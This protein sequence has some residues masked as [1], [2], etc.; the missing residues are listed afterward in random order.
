MVHKQ[1][2]VTFYIDDKKCWKSG[3]TSKRDVYDRF[4]DEIKKRIIFGFKIHKST[5]FKT[6]KEAYKSEQKLFNEIIKDF[7]GYKHK[8]GNVR[9][10]NF[11]TK[12]KYN[13]ITEIRKYDYNEYKYAWDYIANAGKTYEEIKKYP[14]K[15]LDTAGR[16]RI[17]TQN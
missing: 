16:V 12:D 8:D 5:W 6:Y 14:R 4:K 7:G 17:F 3:I 15:N 1:Y 2:L 9:F 13:G 11:Y 10:H